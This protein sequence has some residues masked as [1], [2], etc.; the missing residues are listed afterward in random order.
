MVTQTDVDHLQAE[1]EQLRELVFSD[2]ASVE[3]RVEH[4]IAK[5]DQM[6]QDAQGSNFEPAIESVLSLLQCFQ[7]GIKAQAELN[8]YRQGVA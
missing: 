5:A 2:K 6:R 7:S 4:V 3:N 1:L 8:R